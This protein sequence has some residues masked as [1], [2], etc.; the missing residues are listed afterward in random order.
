MKRRLHQ[1]EAD[2]DPISRKR[3]G[4]S[5]FYCKGQNMTDKRSFDDNLRHSAILN[6]MDRENDED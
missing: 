4:V 2:G 1:R 6:S 3:G 5:L